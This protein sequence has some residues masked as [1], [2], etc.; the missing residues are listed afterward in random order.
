MSRSR[1]LHDVITS[2]RDLSGSPIPRRRGRPSKRLQEKTSNGS[3]QDSDEPSAKAEVPPE[4]ADHRLSST[5]K[6]LEAVAVPLSR[7]WRGQEQRDFS[8]TPSSIS[9]ALSSGDDE[10]DT[11]ETS[12]AVTPAEFGIETRKMRLL[13]KNDPNAS[14]TPVSVDSTGKRKRGPKGATVE[15]VRDDAML[16]QALQEEEYSS[17]RPAEPQALRGR[18]SRI[19]DS[20]DEADESVGSFSVVH[21]EDLPRSRT[22]SIVSSRHRAKRVKTDGHMSLPSRAA[23]D[24]ARKSIAEKTSTRITHEDDDENE[25]QDLDDAESTLSA[26]GSDLDS[27]LSDDSDL[28]TENQEEESADMATLATASAPVLSRRSRR[29]YRERIRP[30]ASAPQPAGRNNV[31]RRAGWLSSRVSGC[32]NQVH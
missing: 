3:V 5:T 22:S 29:G 4:I 1:Q 12:A 19:L 9:S 25:D 26:Y 27:E 18:K 24:S 15:Q 6:I 20:E 21:T 17:A 23:R 7:P 10:Y 11:P 31:S 16:A 28:V 14:R 2:A 8:E 13:G 30:P 32:P